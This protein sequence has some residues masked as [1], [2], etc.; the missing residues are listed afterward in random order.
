MRRGGARTSK[1]NQWLK[2]PSAK[3]ESVE[4]ARSVVYRAAVFLHIKGV[5][6]QVHQNLMDLLSGRSLSVRKE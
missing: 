4:R 2:S 1:L 5:G 6:G 3:G